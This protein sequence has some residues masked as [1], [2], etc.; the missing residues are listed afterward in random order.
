MDTPSVGRRS[1]VLQCHSGVLH[2]GASHIA[3]LL[4]AWGWSHDSRFQ[5]IQ[6]SSERNFFCYG[7]ANLFIA[8]SRTEAHSGSPSYKI[9][10]RLIIFNI[11]HSDYGT[12][13]CVAK[14]PRGETDG[15]IRLYGMYKPTHTFYTHFY[16]RPSGPVFIRTFR[17]VL[18]PPQYEP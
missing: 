2:R 13:K 9:H 10:M 1:D 3:Q 14:N 7:F 4:D 12:Y 5:E 17:A 18:P 6:V 15:T 11:Q 8:F 16:G